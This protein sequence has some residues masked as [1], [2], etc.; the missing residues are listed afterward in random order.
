MQRRDSDGLVFLQAGAKVIR[1]ELEPG[2]LLHVD[3]GCLVVLTGL[4][5]FDVKY[6]RGAHSALLGGEG[7]FFVSLTGPGTNWLQSL[8]VS[9]L[10]GHLARP[11][12]VETK[13]HSECCSRCSRVRL[14]RSCH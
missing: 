13:V 3:T 1:R 10:A 11:P 7:V 12:S 2:E 6:V 5:K 9:R 14:C 4:V 8:P